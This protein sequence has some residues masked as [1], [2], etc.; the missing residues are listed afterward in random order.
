MGQ[1]EM[2]QIKII[3]ITLL[4]TLTVHAG[5]KP[6]K[7]LD[8]YGP[9]SFTLKTGVAYVEIRTYKEDIYAYASEI[10]RRKNETVVFKMYRHP[11]SYFGST[12]KRTFESLPGKKKFAFMKYGNSGIGRSI[13][14]YNNGFMIDDQGKQWRL[15]NVQDVIE[16]VKPIDTPAEL[17]LV[18]WL[19]GGKQ[20]NTTY[21]KIGSGYVIREHYTAIDGPDCGD[22]TFEYKVNRLGKMSKKKLIKFK[23]SK[24]QCDLGGE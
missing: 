23:K 3:L 16:M 20:K 9:K 14:W 15:E 7:S 21:R 18:F 5:W 12:V 1:I 11:L 13:E 2:K 17:M 19:K 4:M 10:S 24:L 8:H 22:Y 6:L